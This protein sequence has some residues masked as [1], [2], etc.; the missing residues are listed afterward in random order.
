VSA[1]ALLAALPAT[2]DVAVVRDGPRVVVAVEPDEVRVA[3]G[4]DALAALDRLPPGWWAGFLT[5]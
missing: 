3:S 2:V 1:A 5:Y 4:A